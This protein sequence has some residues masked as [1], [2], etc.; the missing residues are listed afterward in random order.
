MWVFLGL[1][2]HALKLWQGPKTDESDLKRIENRHGDGIRALIGQMPT[3]SGAK[4]LSRL[5]DINRLRIE[6]EERVY[7]PFHGSELEWVPVPIPWSIW[8][9]IR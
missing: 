8:G 9:E 6:V 3:N 2:A 4:A 1:S 7:A 5:P